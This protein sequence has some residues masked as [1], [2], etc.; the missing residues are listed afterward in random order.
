MTNHLVTFIYDHLC[1]K[2]CVIYILLDGIK[3]NQINQIRKVPNSMHL[4][5]SEKSKGNIV[6]GNTLLG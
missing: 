3:S 4:F 5:I 2:F 1:A 6:L